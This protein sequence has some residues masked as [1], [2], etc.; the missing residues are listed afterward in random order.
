MKRFA[1]AVAAGA[2][3]LA[4]AL[5]AR[6][7]DEGR[8]AELNREAAEHA[9]HEEWNVARALLAEAYRLRPDASL[10]VNLAA[11]ELKSDHPVDALRHLRAY[12]ADP[13]GDANVKQ[14][15]QSDMLPR[16]MAATGHLI[17]HF[18]AGARVTVDNQVVPAAP[19]ATAATDD[20]MPGAHSVD[21]WSAGATMHQS[22]EV[23]AGDSIDVR[24]VPEASPPP[25]AAAVAPPPVENTPASQ[26]DADRLQSGWTTGRFVSL[27]L[28]VG[29]AALAG[30]GTY[31]ALDAS[32]KLHQ[33]DDL[34]ANQLGG[35]TSA[36]SSGG[37]PSACQTA[38]DLHSTFDRDTGLATGFF[39]AG[40]AL[41]V[42][43][44]VTFLLWPRP[45]HERQDVLVRPYVL[46][47]GGGLVGWF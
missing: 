23:K 10:L 34:V 12:L 22:V 46:P 42:G 7:Q 13:H 28:L 26:D 32:S 4:A 17:I 47:A 20:V 44:A 29:G 14:A 3:S 30:V 2:A 45:S 27:G 19:D 24:A 40:G 36:C 15:I 43:A 6:A 11:S 35:S 41:A 9:K 5:P 21:V 18:P 1:I 38:A 31:F 16:A 25:A 33:A 8:A 37:A 39:V